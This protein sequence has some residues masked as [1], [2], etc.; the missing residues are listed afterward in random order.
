MKKKKRKPNPAYFQITRNSY[1]H[2]YKSERK[3]MRE[4]LIYLYEVRNKTGGGKTLEIISK[5]LKHSI[6]T[7]KGIA[8]I[9]VGRKFANIQ[10][11]KSTT[12]YK[13]GCRY[14]SISYQGIRY[15]KEK[16]KEFL[17]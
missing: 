3:N 8:L 12:N 17:D 14:V 4:L 6:P 11:K 9:L 15:L 1:L 5:E 2:L 7:I 16:Y 13:K 10:S